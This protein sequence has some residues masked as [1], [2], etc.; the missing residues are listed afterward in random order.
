MTG[1][2]APLTLRL[3][4]DSILLAAIFAAH[5]AAGGVVALLRLPLALTAAFAALVVVSAAM[6]WRDERAKR[7]FSLVLAADGAA[8]LFFPAG[9]AWARVKPGA[10]TF[11]AVVWFALGWTDVTGRAR[12]R[13]FMLTAGGVEEPDGDAE[14]W[15]RLRV[16]LRHCAL[17]RLQPDDL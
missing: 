11:P 15:R 17:R 9:D 14:Q 12:S 4:T 1:A 2:A 8:R 16:W 3:K 13:R 7:D 5:V 10:V 6:A